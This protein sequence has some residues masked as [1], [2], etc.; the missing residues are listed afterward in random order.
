MIKLSKKMEYALMC[1]KHMNNG[2]KDLFKVKEMAEDLKIPFDSASKSM[3]VLNKANIVR[4][5]QGI[6]GGYSLNKEIEKMSLLDFSK[7]IDNKKY[8]ADCFQNGCSKHDNCNI[9]PSIESLHSRLY[10]ILA[11][12]KISELIR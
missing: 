1:L 2:S 3:Q 7:I 12:I 9:R 5:T 11:K 10:G 4:S 6:S 8:N